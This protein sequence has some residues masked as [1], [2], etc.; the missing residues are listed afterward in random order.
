MSSST[1]GRRR[2][3]AR[4]LH[5]GLVQAADLGRRVVA[6]PDLA[7]VPDV[8]ERVVLRRALQ[9]GLDLVVGVVQPTG[10]LGRRSGESQIDSSMIMVRVAGVR[11]AKRVALRVADQR[12]SVNTLPSGCVAPPQHLAGVR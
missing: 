3:A 4:S 12:C 7:A 2:R 10:E 1:P 11:R 5:A 9:E 6:V 8:A